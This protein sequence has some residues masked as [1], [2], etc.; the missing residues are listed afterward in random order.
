MEYMESKMQ[1]QYDGFEAMVE[2]LNPFINDLLVICKK[3]KIGNGDLSFVVSLF[4]KG[5]M[6]PL[7]EG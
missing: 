6:P 1:D 3:H 5:Y 7:I 4:D 2:D